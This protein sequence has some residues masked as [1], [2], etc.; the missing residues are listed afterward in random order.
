MKKQILSLM[1]LLALAFSLL[2]APAVRAQGTSAVEQLGFGYTW[3][4]INTYQWIEIKDTGTVVFIVDPDPE[5]PSYP[6]DI[7]TEAPI[8][9][10]FPFP[11]FENQ[12][13]ELYISTNG[14]IAFEP[15]NN[16]YASNSL[17]PLDGLP[18]AIIA[19]LWSDLKLW[20]VY[21]AVY[22]QYFPDQYLVIEF[23][24]VYSFSRASS[25]ET[26]TF[27]LILYPNGDIDFVYADLNDIDLTTLTIGFEDA[28]GV[29]GYQWLYNQRPL[30]ANQSVRAVYPRM[31]NA[32][33]PFRVC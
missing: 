13:S 33:K 29:D 30:P 5:N 22:Y 26:L 11:Y 9:I 14:I 24:N 17:I 1:A 2:P 32:S 20:E 12:Y 18:N 3:Q 19:P 4:D 21:S 7:V 28:G 8:P 15:L 6:D 31:A 23:Y 16:S 25:D 10:G 27:E